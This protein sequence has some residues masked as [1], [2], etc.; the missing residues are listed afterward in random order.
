[1]LN[2]P[3]SPYLSL[4]LSLSFP[5]SIPF[6]VH[7]LLMHNNWSHNVLKVRCLFKKHYSNAY[8][9][10]LGHLAYMYVHALNSKINSQV[11]F[12]SSL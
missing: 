5:L 11:E 12:S 7:T 2:Y 3:G 6:M 4:S 8:L 9:V 1:M 10:N